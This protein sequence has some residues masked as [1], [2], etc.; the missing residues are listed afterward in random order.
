MYAHSMEK[1]KGEKMD[2][3]VKIIGV[4]PL[5]R[6]EGNIVFEKYTMRNSEILKK[7]SGLKRCIFKETFR[8]NPCYKKRCIFKETFRPLL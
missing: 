5:V 4:C 8:P 6:G 3:M 7:L 1:H 2:F